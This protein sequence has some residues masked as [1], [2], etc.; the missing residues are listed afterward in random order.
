MEIDDD[1]TITA[2]NADNNTDPLEHF[3]K[4][5][6]HV[7]VQKND[8]NAEKEFRDV[9]VNLLNKM[10]Q[11]SQVHIWTWNSSN[12]VKVI[13]K[14]DDVPQRMSEMREFFPKISPKPNGGFVYSKIYFNTDSDL[15]SIM[16][17]V[18]W[19]TKQKGHNFYPWSVQ[20]ID[21][22]TDAG[23]ILYSTST[24]PKE[25]LSCAIQSHLPSTVPIGLQ[26]KGAEQES[27]V[28]YRDR[29]KAYHLQCDSKD[30]AQVKIGLKRILGH[31]SDVR[32]M[33]VK[34][35]FVPHISFAKNPDVINKIAHLREKQSAFLEHLQS[36]SVAT[37]VD[38]DY[39]VTTDD[40]KKLPTLR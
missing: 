8:D 34:F 7:T 4:A 19:Y 38:L 40:G 10:Q 39:V 20:G 26:W 33:G 18:L 32:L 28:P 29:V 31:E 23:W 14:T 37:F 9:I 5:D 35:R 1:A 2:T 21:D 22:I 25:T 27:R 17:D 13:L 36:K 12:Q 11:Y 16:N 3:T 15:H 24:I 6:F 30:V